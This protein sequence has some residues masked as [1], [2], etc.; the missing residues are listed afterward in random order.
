MVISCWT[1]LTAEEELE[2][3]GA[4]DAEKGKCDRAQAVRQTN[5]LRSLTTRLRTFL[6][7][8][9]DLRALLFNVFIWPQ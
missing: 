9:C 8:L 2:Q 7:Y 1:Q 6:I 3:K 5:A 4:E